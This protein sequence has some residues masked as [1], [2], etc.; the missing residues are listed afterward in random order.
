LPAD[1]NLSYPRC[2]GGWGAC[3]PEDCGGI[4][5]FV[6]FLQAVGDPSND[7]HEELLDWYGGPFDLEAFSV[8]DV[9]QALTPL[10]RRSRKASRRLQ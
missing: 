9:N 4:P 8:E 7:E 3:P 2:T 10:Q 1:P 6:N 5:G